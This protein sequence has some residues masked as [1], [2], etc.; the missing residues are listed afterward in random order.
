[1]NRRLVFLSI[2]LAFP[3]IGL[4]GCW[5]FGKKSRQSP[6]VESELNTASNFDRSITSDSEVADVSS[7][8][9][10]DFF[11][12]YGS[13]YGSGSGL[14]NSVNNAKGKRPSIGETPSGSRKGSGVSNGSAG[15]NNNATVIT[16]N[17]SKNNNNK[18]NKGVGTANSALNKSDSANSGIKKPDASVQT[19]KT[20]PKF[21]GKTKGGVPMYTQEQ[22]DKAVSDAVKKSAA[23]P[24]NGAA[25]GGNPASTNSGSSAAPNLQPAKPAVSSEHKEQASNQPA[26][27]TTAAEV[28]VIQTVPPVEVGSVVDAAPVVPPTPTSNAVGNGGQLAAA[29]PS[30][31]S[32]AVN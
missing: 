15:S 32:V 28:Q 7:S 3:L 18:N 17:N 8:T 6:N 24:N 5:P 1:M 20:T 16:S 12:N 10:E 4:T 29:A 11:T 30:I 13:G 26:V 25:S 9:E 27:P 31:S 19:G 21:D 23:A 14:G 2:I 22:L